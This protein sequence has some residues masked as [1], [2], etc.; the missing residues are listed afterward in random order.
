MMWLR[1]TLLRSRLSSLSDGASLVSMSMGKS[2]GVISL[3]HTLFIFYAKII[4]STPISFNSDN[5]FR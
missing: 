4:K 5:S 3:S 2:P 1:S